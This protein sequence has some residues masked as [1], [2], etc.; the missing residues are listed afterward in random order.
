M[1]LKTS[2]LLFLS[3]LLSGPI[4]AH[5]NTFTNLLSEVSGCN[6]FPLVTK[7]KDAVLCFDRRDFKGVIRAIDDLQADVKR[8]TG[9]ETN[10]SSEPVLPNLPV[11]IGTIGKNKHIDELI[12]S[13]KINV[14]DLK[15]KWESFV[16][17]TIEKPFPGVEQALVI[18][19]SDKRGTIYGIYELSRQLG[20]S[21]WYWW[22]DVP[23]KK[24]SEVYVNNGYY[25]SG[26]PKVKY[27]GIFLNDEIP[28]M[29]NWAKAKFGGMNSQM[30]AHVFELLLRLHANYLWPGMW[31]S[32]KEYNPGVPI[33]KDE[34]GNYEGNSFNEDDPV[35]PKLADEYGIVMG[36][37]HHEP[38]QRS[39]QEWLR[40]KANYGNGE[41]NYM[42]NKEGICKFFKEGIEHTK[43]YESLITLGMRGDDDKPMTDAGSVEANFSILRKIIKDQRK[44]ISD[45]T[46]KP[47]SQMPQVWTLYK[48][49]MEYYDAGL[50]VPDDVIVLLC[51]DD[52]GDVRRLPELKGKRHP[53]GYG[54]YYHV[55]Y[56]GAPR[57]MKWLSGTQI[58][59]MW[60][61]LQLTYDY[62]VDR[63][64]I[65][66]VGDLKACEYPMDF[67]LK[68]AWNPKGFNQNNL[69]E[70]AIGFCAQQFGESQAVE[71]ADL[72]TTYNTYSSR[73]SAEML[74]D[75]TYN[76]NTGEFKMVRDEFMALESRALRQYMTLSP[77]YK[78]TYKELLLFPIQ[79][80]ANLY[81][82]YFSL[83]M[84][85]EKARAKEPTANYWADRVEYC[86]KQDSLLCADYNYNVAGGKW[87]HM[88]DQVHIGYVGWHPPVRNIRP[89]VKRISVD[90][91]KPGNILFKETN[92][93]VVLE[94]EHFYKCK[95]AE[96]ASWSVLPDMG[97]TLSGLTLLPYNQD[98][99]GASL[100]YKMKLTTKTDFVKVHVILNSTMPFK[101][102]G[103]RLAVG[104]DNAKEE[105][106][107]I[108][109][110]LKWGNHYT[111]MYP[112][113]AARINEKVISLKMPEA[114]D[115]IHTIT[116]RP[117]DPGIV[118]Y[119]II[120]DCGGYEDT[121]LKMNESPYTL[122]H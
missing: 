29:T 85:K 100:T 84:N 101:K 21:P 19:G 16:I 119:K 88:M 22:A 10:I 32:F 108:N 122:D 70:Y 118:F 51:D 103:H 31:G 20:V 87:N 2:A 14:N 115:N 105:I 52:W 104:F 81:D 40:N 33:L 83:A 95:D 39:Q 8:V 65:L 121:F 94:A 3:L 102:G 42:T 97:R 78:D 53:G 30:Y 69:K 77:E 113:A 116:F 12:K 109:S 79:A 75:K 71:A 25:A 23:V 45:V 6:T 7:E 112:V 110:D 5:A 106:I 41:W 26:E 58:S 37:S 82:M 91:V 57:A 74:D 56:Y 92:G 67:F 34:H 46:G 99:S 59:K 43:N 1:S 61:Q 35:N 72:L 80:M 89:E 68:M 50:E 111:K 96:N 76:L 73:V 15:N 24:R 66:N 60:E 98:V 55:G 114:K 44:I 17:A 48:E 36:T 18:A 63:I 117:L 28:C 62:G 4:L 120:V 11:I 54:M 64:W 93:V 38:M 107:D 47:A 49:V 86:F 9:H 90:E 27:R 13:K